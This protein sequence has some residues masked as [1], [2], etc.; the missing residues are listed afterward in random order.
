MRLSQQVGLFLSSFLGFVVSTA[1]LGVFYGI[2]EESRVTLLL[3]TLLVAFPFGVFATKTYY[4]LVGFIA[5]F[6]VFFLSDFAGLNPENS[7][8][9]AASACFVVALLM[10]IIAFWKE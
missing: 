9:Y 1:L 3:Y 8:T 10:F 2:P 6:V 5:L 4:S 7:L